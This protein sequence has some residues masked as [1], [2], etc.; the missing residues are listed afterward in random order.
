MA[1]TAQQ[2]AAALRLIPDPNAP[3]PSE[4]ADIVARLLGV[5]EALVVAYA[6][7]APQAV[8]DE[9][10]IRLGGYLYDRPPET[11]SAGAL[12]NSGAQGLLAPYHAPPAGDIDVDASNLATALAQALK[13]FALREGR[14]VGIADMDADA[15]GH[16]LPEGG[17]VGDTLQLL[18][19]ANAWFATI[20]F[21]IWGG[22]LPQE[23]VATDFT[24]PG[25]FGGTA[26]KAIESVGRPHWTVRSHIA[27]AVPQG[28]ALEAIDVNGFNQIGAFS[29]QARTVEIEGD[30]YD[31]WLSNAAWSTRSSGEPF[32]LSPTLHGGPTW[33]PPGMAAALGAGAVTL[34]NLA[35]AVLA[36]MAPALAGNANK[37]LAVNAG[38]DAVEL[39]DAP[40]GGG[41]GGGEVANGS[42]T[43][44]KLAAAVLARMAPD[45][46]GLGGR[47]L[48]VNA[49]ATAVELVAAPTGGGGALA[50]NSVTRAK[51]AE[52]VRYVVPAAPALAQVGYPAVVFQ[53]TVDGGN[54]HAYRVR[55]QQLSADGIANAAVTSAK[56]AAN[57][58][59]A[60]KIAG[61][62]V[63]AAKLADALSARVAP[64]PTGNP[65]K[66]LAAN[67]SATGLEFVD[68]P[69]G[70]VPAWVLKTTVLSAAV[71]GTFGINVS[72]WLT[73]ATISAF[74]EL[75]VTYGNVQIYVPRLDNEHGFPQVLCALA[76]ND[77]DKIAM[78]RVEVGATVSTVRFRA[79]TSA[80]PYI[81]P[82]G[83]YRVYAR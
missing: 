46:T 25:R 44:A 79:V 47:Y 43:L 71:S 52:T 31:V 39:V 35:A 6:P 78:C 51:L 53:G 29:K 58:V 1:L 77:P 48:A 68:A 76:F 8:A 74:K 16:L 66:F 34:A 62:A 36:R 27:I 75:L 9:A 15:M 38:A 33:A 82:A 22:R 63:T 12:H 7:N 56:I 65:S 41:N 59:T 70:S 49:G 28:Y 30:T 69:A 57:A 60:G 81:W 13:P 45:M 17:G 72:S 3:I 14:A 24:N 23:V 4:Y 10:R 18:A 54:V 73:N 19:S 40:E 83:D 64:A 20:R 42:I 11:P 2:F 26:V 5:T 61:K 50:D 32:A 37:Y 55:F 80:A 67:A 21:A